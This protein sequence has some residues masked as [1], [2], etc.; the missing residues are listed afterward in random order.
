VHASD[1]ELLMAVANKSILAPGQMVTSLAQILKALVAEKA[2]TPSA[3]VQKAIDAVQPS[4]QARAIAGSLSSGERVA[5][6]LGNYAQQHP[7]ATQIALLAGQIAALCGAKF[8][9]FGEAA[10]SV[11]AY[12]AGAVPFAGGANGMNAAQMMSAPRK[13]YILLNV[14]PEL[15]MHD[16]QQA[17]AA[18]GGAD[19]V[20]ALSA[21]KHGAS[22]YADVMLPIAPYTETSGTYVSTEGRVQSFRGAVRPL[23]EARPAWKVLRVLGNLLNVS[24][25]EYDDSEAVRDEV[26]TGLELAEKLD[27]ITAGIPLQA[28][29]AGSSSGLQRVS[30]VPI[31][32]SDALVR[33]APS[34][35]S[36][37]DAKAPTAQMH[38]SELGRL[39]VRSGDSVTV[40]QG[41]ATL[42]VVAQANDG[43]PSGTVRLAAGHPDT[44]RLGAMFGTIIVERA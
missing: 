27:N 21:F 3:D 34:L 18:V 36:T 9:Y 6:L 23:G 25:F 22:E 20:V 43:L 35:Q 5:V 33:R 7:D 42:R 29:S 17:M 28:V 14:E 16:P 24:G 10:N 1:D 11:G 19:M 44:A 41:D 39:G 4:D 26:M 40:R 15:D 30:D 8:G 38:S 12:L 32:S 37:H 2:A 31:Y 13:A